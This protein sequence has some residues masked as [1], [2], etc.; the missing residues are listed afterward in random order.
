MNLD[1]VFAIIFYGA[2][3]LYF[4]THRKKFEIQNKIIALYKTKIGLKLMDKFSKVA[5]KFLRVLGIIGI[6]IGF[7]GMITIFVFLTKGL[8]NLFMDPA[9][10]A[11]IGLVLPG[12]R[13]PGAPVY[14][15]FW[16]GIISI[17]VVAVIHEF[18]HGVVARLY[19][20][21]IKSSGI[22][23][24]GPILAAFVEPDE[25][26][27]SKK[28][29]SAQLSIFAAGPFSNILTAGVVGLLLLF[30]IMPFAASILESEGVQ[31]SGLEKNY[32]LERAG[33][34]EGE[35]IEEVNSVPI[36][37]VDDFVEVMSEIKSDQ[38]VILKTNRTLYNV[39]AFEHP[40]IEGKGY[41]GVVVA[42]YITRLKENVVSKFGDKLPWA[43]FG[44]SKLLGWI[45]ALSLGIGLVNLLPLG[46]VDGGRMFHLVSLHFLKDEK[47]SKK[48]WGWMSFV[49]L[50]LIILNI[51]FPYLRKLF[52]WLL[53]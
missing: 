34:T 38:I 17:F 12:I 40:K 51:T 18:S 29:K 28:S 33:V 41:L 44:F 37:N 53:G 22:A 16:Y 5:P 27:L 26:Q 20:I 4:L 30:L 19:N 15:P 9:A 52:N 25:K 8:I 48:V 10:K 23:F 3:I 21:K 1:I 46:P 36:K 47:K 31:I 32:P 35:L 42:P 2:I 45:F 6:G 11:T 43:I 7:I 13:I 14:V 24:F 49:S 39:V 50:M